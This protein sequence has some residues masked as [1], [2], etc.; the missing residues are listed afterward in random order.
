MTKITARRVCQIR[1]YRS[2]EKLEKLETDEDL[3]VKPRS[4]EHEHEHEQEGQLQG[5]FSGRTVDSI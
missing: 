2:D 4:P 1:S 5:R 3:K